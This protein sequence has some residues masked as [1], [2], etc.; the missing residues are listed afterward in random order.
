MTPTDQP[1]PAPAGHHFTP[2]ELHNDDVAHEHSDINIRVILVSG[3]VLAVVALIAA[4]AMWVLFRV[5]ERQASARDPQLSPLAVPAGQLPPLPRLQTNEPAGLQKFRATELKTLEGYG[6][7]DE[8]A[9]IAHIPVEEAKKKL[10]EHGVAS[11][12]TAADPAV[13]THAPAYGESSGGRRIFV[14]G[15]AA[16]PAAPAAAQTPPAAAAPKEPK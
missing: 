12:A 1:R 5:L 2:D 11:R 7:V 13:G 3:V 6:W 4:G 14:P 16:A 10:V 9:R 15:P 8:K